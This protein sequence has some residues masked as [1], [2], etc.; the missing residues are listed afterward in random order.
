MMLAGQALGLSST[1]MSRLEQDL[2]IL[3]G[4]ARALTQRWNLALR[5]RRVGAAD[6]GSDRAVERK[7]G[8]N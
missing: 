3:A 6:D 5:A 1:A 4:V 8:T 2:L 7:N